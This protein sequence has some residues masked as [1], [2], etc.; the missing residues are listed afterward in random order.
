[1]AHVPSVSVGVW[2]DRGSRHESAPESGISHFIEHMVFK[3]TEHRSQAQIAQEMDA[4]GGQTDAFTSHESAG[5]H[6]KVL[7]ED[8]PRAMDLLSDIVLAPRFDADELE[9]E[10]MVIFEEIK[11]VEDSPE[12]LVHDMFS[13]SFW[14][15]HPLGRRILGT[16]DTVSRFTRDDLTAF[17]RKIYA[18]SN[19]IVAAAGHLDHDRLV[20]LVASQFARLSTP[21]DGITVSPPDIAARV[22]VHEKDLE[23]AH[24]VVGTL[25]PEAASSDRFASSVLN[26]VLGGNLSSRLFQVIREERGLA[27]SVYSGIWSF[28]DCGQFTVYAG[29]DPKSVGDVLELTLGE[30][31]RIKA[32]PLPAD[33]LERAKAHVR[34]AT[35]M[36][37]ESTGAR[38]SRAARQEMTFGRHFSI[39]ETLEGFDAVTSEDVLRLAREMFGDRPLA[40]TLLGTELDPVPETLVA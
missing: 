38:M 6:A 5:F 22:R 39:E 35:L 37:L 25:A 31:G 15:H 40:M 24:L 7:G 16:P 23:Q 29:T 3:G 18:P 9:R 34:R 36:S 8:L 27:Y 19:I 14:P 30:L 20:E 13:E 4:I 10:R 12:E 33:E 32:E 2:L 1:M 26:A 17:F 21:P 28:S 11:S